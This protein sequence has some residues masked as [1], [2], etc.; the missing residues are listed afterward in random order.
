MSSS[1]M[2]KFSAASQAFHD[3][4]GPQEETAR[5]LE[6]TFNSILKQDKASCVPKCVLHKRKTAR[7][8]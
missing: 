3:E 6:S 5:R 4:D 1:T 2:K 7:N 8:A